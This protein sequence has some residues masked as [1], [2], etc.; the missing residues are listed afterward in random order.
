MAS[1]GNAPA[2]RFNK[3]FGDGKIT[4]D[5]LGAGDDPMA[6][7]QEFSTLANNPEALMKSR[8]Q[9]PGKAISR[10]PPVIDAFSR[11]LA[12]PI[13]SEQHYFSVSH[14]IGTNFTPSSKGFYLDTEHRG[15]VRFKPMG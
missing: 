14:K 6:K 5:L 7:N 9:K 15:L 8:F 12:A 1:F 2:R 10:F 3:P 13:S 11:T 4:K